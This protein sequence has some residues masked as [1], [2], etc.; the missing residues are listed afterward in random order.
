MSDIGDEPSAVDQ[1]VPNDPLSQLAM[2]HDA[3]WGFNRYPPH[4]HQRFASFRDRPITLLE[5]GIGG[6]EDPCAGGN[7]LRLWRDYFP[8]A[9]IVGLD[10]YDKSGLDEDRILTVRGDQS[11]PKFLENLATTH[12]PFDIIIDDGSHMPPHIYASFYALFRY[13]RDGGWYVIEDLQTSYW[14]QFDGT[15]IRGARPSTIDLLRDLMDAV[16]HAELDVVGY[17]PTDVDR[18]ILSVEV[19]RGIAFMR[20][21][22]NTGIDKRLGPHPRDHLV[23][24]R[25]R[26][27]TRSRI[28]QKVRRILT[29][30]G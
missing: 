29:T 23:F 15:S 16:H 7:S 13:V 19:M 25:P 17:E 3:K 10:I 21:G 6:Y 28:K 11:D 20:K 2:A 30:G 18:S 22:D 4:Y 27:T 9:K 5:I 26:A 14:E 1:T 24:A 8:Q 12:G